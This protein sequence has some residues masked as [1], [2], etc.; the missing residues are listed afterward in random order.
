MCRPLLIDGQRVTELTLADGRAHYAVCFE[1][2]E[3][4]EPD[5]ASAADAGRMGAALARLH[6][7][8]SHLPATPLPPVK[9]LRTL[10][11]A[12]VPATGA[13]QLLH[14]D[15]NASNLR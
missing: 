14:G 13:H 7:S 10:S 6:L 4:T 3:G 1:F 9:A 5:P 2:A 15:F 8:M 11:A 12:D